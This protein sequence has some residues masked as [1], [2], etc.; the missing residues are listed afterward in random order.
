MA[1]YGADTLTHVSDTD[2]SIWER[3]GV[4]T[5]LTY[6]LINDDGMAE[7]TKLSPSE[8]PERINTLI[9]T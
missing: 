5:Q 4:T 7:K 3:Y 9:A 8:L 6:V 2:N 1:T